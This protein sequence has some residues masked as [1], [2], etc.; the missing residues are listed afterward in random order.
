MRADKV[1]HMTVILCQRLVGLKKRELGSPAGD[2]TE[3]K[4]QEAYVFL[5][6]CAQC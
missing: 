5:C 4:A 3:V 6:Q 2:K 1:R